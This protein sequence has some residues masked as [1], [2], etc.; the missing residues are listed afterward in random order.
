[1]Q[2]TIDDHPAPHGSDRFAHLTM[3]V[4]YYPEQWP[5]TMWEDDLARMKA[6][7][8]TV[9]RVAEFAWSVFEPAEGV[10][11]FSLFDR[12]LA[13]C[14]DRDMKVI[15]GTPTATPP[16]WLTEKYPEVLN[17]DKNGHLLRHGARRHYNYNS[18]V[19]RKLCAGIVEALA[20]CYGQHPAVIGWQLDN[21]LNCETDE[22][23]SEA[24]HAAFR[25]FV[26]EKYGTLDALNDAWGTRFWSQT[27][28]DWDQ[29]YAPRTVLNDGDNPHL[30]LDYSR[31]VS[32]SC[33]SFAA[34]Q[35]DI[36][37]KYQKDG[38]F[39]TTNG[40]FANLDSHRLQ[41]E[42][43]DLFTFD[44]YPDFAFA[45]DRGAV[46]ARDIRDRRWSLRL[47][48]VRSVCPH[49]GIMEQQSGPGGWTS[50][51]E[52]PVPRPGQ[53]RLWALQSVAHGADFVSF[54]RWR[55]ATF[56]T[57]I[58]WHGILDYDNRDNRRLREAGAL[59]EELRKLDGV[60]GADFAAAFGVLH[61]Y[62]NEWDARYDVWHKRI[63]EHSEKEIFAYAQ[64]RHLPFDMVDLRDTT[65]VQALCRYPVLIYPHPVI[66][67][68]ARAAVLKAYVEQGGILVIG[69]R[70]GLKDMRGQVV[71]MPQPGLLQEL[72]GTDVREFT[73][74]HPDEETDADTPVFNDVLTPLDGTRA[75]AFYR[76]SY[77]KGEACLTVRTAGKGKVLHLGSA[78]S[79]GMLEKVFR[80]AG[81]AEFAPF[82]ETVSAPEDVELVLRKKDDRQFMFV[83]NYTA[84]AQTV[85]WKK[86]VTSLL[87]GKELV[88]EDVIAPFGVEVV[89]VQ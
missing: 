79:E 33:V 48:K 72:T 87:G 5:E 63:A 40:M 25:R 29:V 76:H 11:D 78:F 42:A 17:A 62:D 12:F 77:Y 3:G 59:A 80:E 39:V 68:A 27:Y 1:M 18:P 51:M 70:A 57:E 75:L 65:P 50:C 21:E 49:F 22:F 2:T 26:R 82:A 66:M 19:Y 4:C 47:T 37:R 9:V 32:E 88:G 56:G 13:L 16:A 31:F 69:C 81:A 28:T 60:C 71:M 61:D 67:T 10:Y 53:L 84:K 83:L 43:L 89:E 58:Y 74:V 86:A 30:L 35:T 38:D 55:T 45:R 73:F 14:A 44:S 54:F 7:G 6:L 20:S 23:Y 64:R 41:K 15:F 24:D 8:I 85:T 52:M 46:D 36:I 34:L